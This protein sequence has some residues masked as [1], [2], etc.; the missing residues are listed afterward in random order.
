MN[1]EAVIERLPWLL[2]RSLSA[3]EE[4]A[5][6][7]HVAG[8]NACREDL[9]RT[10]WHWEAIRCHLAP[11][12]LVAHVAGERVEGLA[13]EVITAHLAACESCSEERDLLAAGREA[14]ER[15]PAQVRTGTGLLT[16]NGWRTLAIAAS[17]FGVAV[18]AGW[19]Q[20]QSVVRKLRRGAAAAAIS[21]PVE[22]PTLNVPI[23]ELVPGA[24]LRGAGEPTEILLPAGARAVTL[25]LLPGRVP[26]QVPLSVKILDTAGRTAWSGA[27]LVRS[28]L[29]DFTLALP[30][31]IM[32][33]GRMSLQIYAGDASEPAER[34]DIIVRRAER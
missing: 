10:G 4:Q 22:T 31:S 17:L 25:I 7:D 33:P 27:G 2:N 30:T 32:K 11:E 20:Q 18:L 15:L 9:E 19:F 26:H 29:G 13:G 5:V 6:R 16:G 23:F 24:D 34:Y 1:C 21:G 14:V 28:P 12:I 3:D 8:C